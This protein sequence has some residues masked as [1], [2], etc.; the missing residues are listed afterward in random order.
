MRSETQMHDEDELD[1]I[2][3]G[4]EDESVAEVPTGPD[5]MAKILD[6][7]KKSVEAVEEGR[8]VSFVVEDFDR[9]LRYV[10]VVQAFPIL[11]ENDIVH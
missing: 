8:P 4:W 1:E 7:T 2:L 9:G 5:T 3:E 10:V 11:N 6:C